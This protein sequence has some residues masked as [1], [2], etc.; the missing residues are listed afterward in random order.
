MEE[1]ALGIAMAALPTE[2]RMLGWRIVK[3]FRLLGCRGVKTR[4]RNSFKS[5]ERYICG[6]G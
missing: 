3:M 6:P 1:D 5:T 2:C 4:E